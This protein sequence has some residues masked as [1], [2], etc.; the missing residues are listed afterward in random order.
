MIL[1]RSWYHPLVA[2]MVMYLPPTSLLIGLAWTQHQS[3]RGQRMEAER[4]AAKAIEYALQRTGSH[5]V[6][7]LFAVE[8]RESIAR[9][10]TATDLARGGPSTAAASDPKTKTAD[11]ASKP[12]GSDQYE[13]KLISQLNQ[14]QSQIE[15][16]KARLDRVQHDAELGERMLQ[17]RELQLIQR[18]W[19]EGDADSARQLFRSLTPSEGRDGSL[20]MS[21]LHAWVHPE[22]LVLPSPSESGQGRPT[23][24]DPAAIGIAIL[25]GNQ[26]L[27]RVTA[28]GVELR[29]LR[30]GAQIGALKGAGANLTAF[31]VN[32]RGDRIA[33]ANAQGD[34]WVWSST[35]RDTPIAFKLGAPITRIALSSDG[36]KLAALSGKEVQLWSVASARRLFQLSRFAC[37]SL[38]FH[39]RDERLVT[40]DDEGVVRLFSTTDGSYLDGYYAHRQAILAL[41][42]APDGRRLATASLDR[43]VRLWDPTEHRQLT[44]LIGQAAPVRGIVW[45]S[46]GQVIATGGDDQI[47]RLWESETGRLRSEFRGH[48]HSIRELALDEANHA[49]V[50]R[51]VDGVTRTWSIERATDLERVFTLLGNPTPGTSSSAE[52]L[53]A[54]ADGRHVAVLGGVEAQQ[55]V[56][57]IALESV[58]PPE[59]LPAQFSNARALGPGAQVALTADLRLLRRDSSSEPLKLPSSVGAPGELARAVFSRDGKQVALVTRTGRLTVCD[60]SMGVALHQMETGEKDPWEL[61]ARGDRDSWLLVGRTVTEI[62]RGTGRMRDRWPVDQA[63]SVNARSFTTRPERCLGIDQDG[64]IQLSDPRSGQVL[65]TLRETNAIDLV[66]VERENGSRLVVLGRDGSV[67]VSP[68]GDGTGGS[69]AIK[70]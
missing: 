16:L 51:A 25:A 56:T 23:Q 30:T 64:M 24:P 68:P 44:E 49:I 35:S 67:R 41:A 38:S 5:G 22:L 17:V 31:A 15:T 7:D 43:T 55:P 70:K 61:L 66:V 37:A 53:L 28:D 14:A 45:T 52:R 50:A 8:A 18:A 27:A 21:L 34:V 2:L 13:T 29:D 1:M 60:T 36:E 6:K 12:S 10:T 3:A 26:S 39:P 42:F 9:G 57:L 32:S 19:R 54:S 63:A 4:Q 59:T 11:P 65:L 46:D 58:A 69:V 62:D 48:A 47:A 40:G 33:V 20:E